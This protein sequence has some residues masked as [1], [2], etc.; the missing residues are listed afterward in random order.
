M[1]ILSAWLFINE[2]CS[3]FLVADLMT[4][5]FK[6][7]VKLE[8]VVSDIKFLECCVGKELVP[9]G[10]KWKLRVQGL[11]DDVQE[12]VELIKKD[13]TMRV[14]DVMLKGLKDKE[15]VLEEKKSH[16]NLLVARKKR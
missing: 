4:S 8:N 1:Y 10:L 11:G 12:R 6:I 14:L 7:A 3:F 15:A 9:S 5:S 13:A 2:L 16:E